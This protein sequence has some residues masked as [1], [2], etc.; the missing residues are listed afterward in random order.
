MILVTARQ[1]M[2][3]SYKITDIDKY[4]PIVLDKIYEKHHDPIWKYRYQAEHKCKDCQKGFVDYGN[5]LKHKLSCRKRT[6]SD[7]EESARSL[8]GIVYEHKMKGISHISPPRSRSKKRKTGMRT[9]SDSKSPVPNLKR[10]KM[11]DKKPV[12]AKFL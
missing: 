3:K 6:V 4:P 5:F 2:F 10:S 8:Y 12:D 11:F 7:E 1:D 9:R